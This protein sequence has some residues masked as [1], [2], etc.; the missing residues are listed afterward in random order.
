MESNRFDLLRGK[1]VGLLT[2]PAGVNRYGVSTLHVLSTSPLVNL[3]ALYGPEHGIYGDEE[4]G[5]HIENRND[6]RT[7]LP[8]YSLYGKYRKPTPEMLDPIDTLVIDLQ[9][10]GT[11]SY[12]FIS[13]MK[14]ALE[15]CFESN[16]EVIVLDR[17][18]P[19]GGLKVDGPSI[20]KEWMSY[21]GAFP[22]PYVHGLTIG[23][24]ARMAVS[25]QGI[26]DLT[27][28][29]RKSGKLTVVTMDG[30]RRYMSWPATGL[31]WTAASPNIPD[32]QA[33]VG[34][35]M[36]G[37]GAQI[38][39]LNHGIGTKYPFR[40]LSCDGLD[41]DELIFELRR[42]II[43][44]VTFQSMPYS[45]GRGVYVEISNWNQ[46]RPTELNFHMM[47]ISSQLGGPNPFASASENDI[48]FYNKLVGSNAWW[49]E[50]SQKG[51]ASN[52]SG[53]IQAWE[54]QAKQFQIQSRQYWLYD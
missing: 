36:T 6:P 1:R 7:G 33:A 40:I 51:S 10:I 47:R 44:G 15:A 27:D 29:Q 2:H 54:R 3:T 22:V 34:Y 35:A 53:Y 28:S 49:R 26:L 23:E 48:Q 31:R 32:F 8:I 52:F 38:G 9:D 37:L 46:W 50:I 13:C 20:E 16:V 45:K 43:P 25:R 39:Y 4:A 14:L 12:T 11:R 24:L 18:N 17:P 30:W 41:A 5:V 42:Q 21:V 19:L